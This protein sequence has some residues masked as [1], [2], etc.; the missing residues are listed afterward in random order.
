[1]V[2]LVETTDLSKKFKDQFVLNQVNIHVPESQVYC[3]LGPNG[4]GKTT[5]M[6]I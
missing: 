2:N 5:L 4:A 6:K 3:L 1:M